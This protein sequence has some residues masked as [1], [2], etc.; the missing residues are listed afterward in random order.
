MTVHRLWLLPIAFGLALAAAPS[1]PPCVTLLVRPHF[2]LQR[3]DV[4]IEARVPRHADNRQLTIAWDSDN[5]S[6]GATMRPLAGEDA[7]V[8]HTL[9]LPSQPSANYLFVATVF[10]SSGKV[11]GRAEARIH[12]PGGGQ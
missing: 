12:S 7:Q 1:S 4:R 3:G 9:N 2:L 10:A 6:A 5:G 11:R 8:L